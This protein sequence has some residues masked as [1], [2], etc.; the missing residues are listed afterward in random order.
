[1]ASSVIHLAV[2]K[3]LE[4]HKDSVILFMSPNDI[5]SLENELIELLKKITN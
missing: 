2:A 4:K 1:M 5:S 3:E